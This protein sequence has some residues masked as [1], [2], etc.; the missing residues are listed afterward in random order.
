MIAGLDGK[1]TKTTNAGASWILLNGNVNAELTGVFMITSDNAYITGFNGIILHTANGGNNWVQQGN[2]SNTLRA[3]YFKDENTGLIA[4]YSGKILRTTNG[5]SNWDSVISGTGNNLFSVMFA[6]GNTSIAV[7]TAVSTRSSDAGLNWQ[8][9]PVNVLTDLYSVC[10][11][12]AFTGYAAGQQ[13]VIL[14]TTTGGIGVEQIS[15]GVPSAFALYQ[16]YPNPFNP[17]TRIRFDIPEQSFVRV[18]ISD[19]NGKRLLELVNGYLSPGTY[20]AVWDASS[21]ASGVYF[22]GMNAENLIKVR[23]MILLK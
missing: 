13:G 12:N 19:V 4:G 18:T 7:G 9:Q 3:V 15:S 11:V 22:Y 21:Y 14:K 10:F 1:I 20:E 8:T 23:K 5:G 2:T 6:D 16:N 17:V